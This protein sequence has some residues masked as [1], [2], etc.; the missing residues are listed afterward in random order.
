MTLVGSW[1]C[2]H[3]GCLKH[4]NSA[5]SREVGHTC[6]G[7]CPSGKACKEAAWGHAPL[8]PHAYAEGLVTPG[9]CSLCRQSAH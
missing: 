1:T 2:E 6:C 5:L 8:F 7:R 3:N 4:T 9:V